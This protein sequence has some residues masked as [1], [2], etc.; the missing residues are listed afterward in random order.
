MD[1]HV[2]VTFLLGAS[3]KSLQEYSLSRLNHVKEMEKELRTLMR[4]MAEEMAGAMVAAILMEDARLGSIGGHPAQETLNFEGSTGTHP[5]TT[6][7]PPDRF[8]RNAAD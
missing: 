3:K 1:G 7:G 4:G 5:A 6:Q 8:K 2:P